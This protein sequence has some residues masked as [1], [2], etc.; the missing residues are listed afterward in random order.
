ME[1]ILKERGKLSNTEVR[2]ISGYNRI[3]VV[4]LMRK[5]LTDGRVKLVG[6]GRAGADGSVGMP[7]TKGPTPG[8]HGKTKTCEAGSYDTIG[9]LK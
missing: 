2:R 3:E 9:S 4:R 7:I 1:A 6:R 8:T 5:L